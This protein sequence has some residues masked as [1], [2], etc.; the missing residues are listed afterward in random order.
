MDTSLVTLADTSVNTSVTTVDTS[1]PPFIMNHTI[2]KNVSVCDLIQLEC[3]AK[4]F[5]T[6]SIKWTFN[7]TEYKG[8]S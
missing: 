4:G 6:P 1:S 2:G 8:K 3:V 5:P 7:G